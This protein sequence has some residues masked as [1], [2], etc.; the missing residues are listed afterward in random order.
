[1]NQTWKKR[2]K[3]RKRALVNALNAINN[4]EENEKS[5]SFTPIPIPESVI[6]SAN[7]SLRKKIDNSILGI[8]TRSFKN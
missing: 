4:K 3:N 1:M 7:E 2:D 6:K 8:L 5:I